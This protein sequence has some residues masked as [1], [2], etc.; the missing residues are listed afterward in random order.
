[1]TIST[2][3]NPDININTL[4]SIYYTYLHSVIK[5]GIIFWGNSSNTGKV[6]TLQKNIVRIMALAQCRTSCRSL[7][8]H[9]EILP[10]LC[11]YILSLMNFILSHQENF[12]IISS[13]HNINARNKHHL[14]GPMPIYLV[15][16]KVRVM[17]ASKFSAACHIVSQSLRMQRQNLK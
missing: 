8:K 17:Q 16:K 11:Q 6:F 7:F 12:T 9:L 5:Y 4:K 14:H 13:M 3:I 1:V 2:Y 10:V 15:L